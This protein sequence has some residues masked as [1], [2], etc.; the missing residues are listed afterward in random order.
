MRN[1]ADRTCRENQ[2]ASYVKLPLFFRPKI[3]P[4]ELDRLQMTIWCMCIEF[5]IT[6][7][8]NTLS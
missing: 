7:A 4:G 3:V 1:V 5:W 8:T 2:N 6:N